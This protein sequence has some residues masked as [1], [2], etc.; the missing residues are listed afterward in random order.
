MSKTRRFTQFI[1]STIVILSMSLSVSQPLSASAQGGDGIQRQVNAETGRVSFIGPETGRVVPAARAL[2]SL[3]RAAD[4]ALALA[5]RF[6]PE[7][8]LKDPERDLTEMKANHPGDGRITVRYQ[9]NYEGVPVMGGE[10]IVNT[11]ENGDLYSMNG[12]VS[13]N[14]SLSTEPTIDSAQARESALQAAAKWYQ[15]TSEDFVASEPELWI[16]DESLLNS[17]TRPAELVWRMEV[18][19]VG[20]SLPVRELV[21]INA[22]RGNISLHF[23]QVDTAWG[24]TPGIATTVQASESSEVISSSTQS[25]SDRQTNMSNPSSEV[26]RALV[27]STWYVATTGNNSNSCSATGSPCLTINGAIGKAANG[28]TIKVASGT[29]I[30][31]GTEVV[32]INKNATLS[33]GWNAGFTT[34]SGVST[35]NG[36]NSRE[37]VYATSS[38]TASLANFTV[39]NGKGAGHGGGVYNGG[40]LTITNSLIQNNSETTS[41]TGGGG[42]YND[43]NG[44]LTLNNTIISN[45]SISGYSSVGGGIYNLG[46]LIITQSSIQNN[47]AS[48]SSQGGGGICNYYGTL[49]LNN[50]T[51]SGNSGA[52]GGGICNDSGALTLNNT[53]VSG[54]FASNSGGGISSGE[55][56]LTLNNTTV[57]GNSASYYGGGISNHGNMTLSNTTVTNNSSDSGGGITNFGNNGLLKNSI[58]AGNIST[59]IYDRPNCEGNLVSNGYNLIVT[60]TDCNFTSTDGDQVGTTINPIRP[61]L[62]PLQNNGGPTLTHA[63]MEGSPAINA[64]NP[65]APGNGGSTCSVTDQRGVTRPVGGRCD[66]GAYEGSVP[67][68]PSPYVNTYTANGSSSLP[69]SFICNESD[70]NCTFGD[71]HAKAAHKYAI[72]TY[73]FYATQHGRDSMD[74]NG[75]PIIS[76]VH[77]C[78]PSFCPYH[79]AFWDGT[80]MVFGDGYGFALAD[81][82]VAHEF[83]HSVTEHESNLFYYYQSGAI[84]ESFSDVWGE[85]Y[86]QTNGLGNDVAGVK[87]QIGEDISGLG[88]NRNMSNPPA[89]G[90]PDKMSSANYYEGQDD[91]GGVHTNSGIN[92]K[93]VF[94]MVDGGTFNGK[95]VTAL[96]WVKT[97]AIYYEVNTNLLSSGADYSDLYYALQQACSSLV[98]QKGITAADC[99]EVKDAIDAVEMNSQPAPNF[100][101]DAPFCDLG[102]LATTFSDNLESGTGNWT[103]TNGATIRWQYDT[104][105]PFGPY[106]H[107]GNHSLFANDYPA[108]ITDANARLVSVPI[109]NNAYLY[110]AHTYGFESN[111]STYYDGGVLEYSING[112]S[113]WVDAGSLINFN[114]YDGP[115]YVGAGN[116]LSGRSAFVGDSHGYIS[117]RLNLASLAGK[118]VTFRWR[119]GLDEAYSAWGWWVDDVKVYTCPSPANVSLLVGASNLGNY[120]LQP[121]TSLRQSYAGIDNGPAKVMSTNGTKIVASERVAYSPDGGTTWTSHSELMGLPS[122]QLTSSYTFP[123]YN[124]LDLN[125]QLRF[126]NAGTS[127]TT[128]TVT[129]GGAVQGSYPLAPN[130]STRVS[131]LGLDNGPV[132]ITSSG[133]VPIIASMRVAYF[134]GTAWTSFSEMMGLPSSQ[135]TTSYIFPWYNNLDLNSQLRFGNVGT[136]N[137]TVTVTIG[138][139][140]QGSYTLI[141]N[142]SRRVSYAGLDKGPVKITSSGGIPIIASMRVAYHDGSAW[143]D[144]SEM[145]GL[146]SSS[147]STHYSFPA[148]NNVNLN[149]QLRFGN[150]GTANTTVTVTVNGVVKGTYNLAPNASQRVSYAGLNSGPVVIQ[151]SGNVPIIASERVAYFNGS[152]WTSFAEM[153]GLPQSQLTTTFLFPWYNNLD[154][155][156]QLRFGVP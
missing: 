44:S 8:G 151:S 10:L 149:T 22:Q 134:N 86:D 122:N 77:Y 142:E 83:T 117:T 69:G 81:D 103:F 38:V 112:G 21:L 58:L 37:G 50:T 138:G 24:A 133:N 20:N 90:D 82:V 84:N 136:A 73:N 19:L 141:P 28:D 121:S 23:N 25:A 68:V 91:S 143:T 104:S 88:A 109:P 102:N 56:T 6:A 32:L 57:S 130:A 30:G 2:G 99:L 48:S 85:Y 118:S 144:F 11:N 127:N 140:V 80:Q 34:Q 124:N 16:F 105:E 111:A 145:M 43:T 45:N 75:M 53:T 52:S 107:S 74:N 128:V 115:I 46:I 49:T 131:Y 4:P 87:W 101:T 15:K 39:N 17:S 63:L 156:S 7:F 14:L 147:L 97:A 114:G 113:T 60:N 137:T 9:Q 13:P 55:G 94:L 62:T 70:P 100:N 96:G 125:S 1:F 93:A 148:Y 153:M 108:S 150:V 42:I 51:V 40:N 154:L 27:G 123:W 65:A 72:G 110:F 47:S 126:G 33:G 132:K 64:G 31:T 106:A 41:Y 139:V 89:L 152:A 54:N 129:I 92:N 95:T 79:N 120:V 59:G 116:P 119:M 98:G 78:S 36:E 71:S 66:I 76:S 67:W 12:E 29:Y 35:I 155:N 61:R 3:A 26:P 18:T 146:P 5:K 135:L